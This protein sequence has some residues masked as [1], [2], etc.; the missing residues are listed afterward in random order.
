MQRVAPRATYAISLAQL[1]VIRLLTMFALFHV[2]VKVNIMDEAVGNLTAA[3]KH[4][5]MDDNTLMVFSADN[6]VYVSPMS[7]LL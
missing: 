4:K 7:C 3:L 5:H 6:G 2:N 1:H